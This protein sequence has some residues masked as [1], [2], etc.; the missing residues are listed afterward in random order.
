M[1]AESDLSV[2]ELQQLA[3]KKALEKEEAERKR[4]EA[5]EEE[6]RKEVERGI[7]WGMAEDATEEVYC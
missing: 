4:K 5:R 1:E 2:T 3:R 6:Q 7:S